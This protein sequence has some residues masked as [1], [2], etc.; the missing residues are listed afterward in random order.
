MKGS[1]YS[2]IFA[3]IPGNKIKIQGEKFLVEF[4]LAFY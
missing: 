3:A 1:P 2:S 4:Q